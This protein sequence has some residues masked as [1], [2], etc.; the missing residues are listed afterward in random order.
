[1]GADAEVIVVGVGAMGAA[2][3]SALAR[4]GVA[5]LGLERFDVPHELGSSGGRT[6]LIRKA[7]Y[8]HPDYVPLLHSAYR[9]WD[10]LAQ[11]TGER[12]FERCGCLFLGP[13]D[14]ALIRGTRASAARHGLAVEALAAREV[15]ARWSQFRVRCS[16]AMRAT[17]R[18][19]VRSRRWSLMR[20][21]TGRACTCGRP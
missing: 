1:V 7:Y 13:P 19:I 16:S 6:R 14:T 8:E 21:G 11:R 5:V 10:E 9:G 2:A 18:A 17:S 20:A 3:C 15:T 12:V 4:R